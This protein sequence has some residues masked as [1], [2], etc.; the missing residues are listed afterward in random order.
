MSK[1]E[2]RKLIRLKKKEY[3]DEEL[4]R[5]SQNIIKSLLSHPAIKTA[6]TV[7]M[8]YSLPDEVYTHNAINNLVNNGKTVLLPAVIN[9]QEMVLRHYAGTGDLRQGAFD[10]MEPTGEI[11]T[12]YAKVDVAI[13]PGMGFDNNN[14]RLGR[15]KGY[16]DRFLSKMP[17][18]YKIGI[19]FDFQK[20]SYIPTDE[21]DIKMD[22]VISSPTIN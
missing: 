8:Y 21:N 16:Y 10:I 7:V 3:D 14:N 11:F 1:S 22:E 2:L 5:M 17:H 20:Y 12:D 13:I 6:K 18:V 19:C 4:I 15:G 9:E